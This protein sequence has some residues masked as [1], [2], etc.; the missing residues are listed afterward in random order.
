MYDKGK[1][2]EKSMKKGI[3][4]STL[5]MIAIVTMLIDHIG[6]VLIERS[7]LYAPGS[8]INQMMSLP[9]FEVDM[10]LR[11][12]G[13]IAFPIFAFLLVEGMIHTR[14]VKKYLF[15]MF[16]FGLVSEIPFD[17]AL[18]GRPVNMGYQNVFFTLFIAGVVLYLLE[19]QEGPEWQKQIMRLGIVILGMVAATLLKT[20]YS[21][22][23][24][25]LVTILYVY[26]NN[27][28]L[29]NT[30]G[31]I[32]VAFEITAP[33]AFIPIHFYNGERGWSMKYFFYC[34]YPAHLLILYFIGSIL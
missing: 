25:L 4:G 3:T 1:R 26:R 19:K 2:M 31:C 17:L 21:W 7:F 10:V 32:C 20:D 22:I 14:D 33:L 27:H 15:R 24:I 30:F 6:A 5:K 8:D 11:F 9:W 23:G 29:R 18:F 13:R 12:I 16:I 34:F 28:I